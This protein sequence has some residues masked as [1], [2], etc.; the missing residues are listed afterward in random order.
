MGKPIDLKFLQAVLGTLPI[1]QLTKSNETHPLLLGQIEFDAE[2]IKQRLA[3]DEKALDEILK[4]YNGRLY[5]K[6]SF[7]KKLE[8]SL[9]ARTQERL[10]DT[11]LQAK[12]S[13]QIVPSLLQKRKD[14][15]A[16]RSEYQIVK[17]KTDFERELVEHKHRVTET[18]IPPE[19]FAEKMVAQLPQ[20]N[21][22]RHQYILGA[23]GSG[24][25][26]LIKL[27]AYH[28]IQQ[29]NHGVF[30]LDPHGELCEDII[31]FRGKGEDFVYLS[32]EF[33]NDGICFKYNIFDHD[34]HDQPDIVKQPFISMR[35]E[36]LLGSFEK[37]F[38]A[39]FTHYMK[40]L[41]FNSMMLL[42]NEK[43][44]KLQDLLNLLRPSTE[45]KYLKMAKH[46]YNENVRMYFEYD[47]Q[48]K[49]L[50]ITRMSV[51]TRFE[52]ALSNYHLNNIMDAEK[53]SFDLRQLLDS[54]KAVLMSLSQGI[55]G[56]EG[57]RILGIFLMSELTTHALRRQN[58]PKEERTP[59]FCYIDEMHNYCSERL[60]KILSEGR[61]Y[62]IHLILANQY[63][64]QFGEK[65]RQLKESILAN[66]NIKMFGATSSKDYTRMAKE[67]DFYSGS[68]PMLRHG[69]FVLKVGDCT[70]VL[71][72]A[73][74]HLV[75]KTAEYYLPPT[76]VQ[77]RLDWQKRRYYVSFDPGQSAG[78]TTTTEFQ[79]IIEKLI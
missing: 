11:I 49:P 31:R 5:G 78:N 42:L 15:T 57:S 60:D 21:R 14:F 37:I 36:E 10:K 16:P 47:F 2:D 58:Q 22:E 40:R 39:D 73:S 69:K 64:D 61:K 51:I 77:K 71:V 18:M 74:G 30:V 6:L 34:Y 17:S 70:P 7:L 53:S 45:G 55:I 3:K 4:Y 38:E 43:G 41:I 46:H 68:V 25:S 32:A 23:S 54:S 79:P 76:Q 8:D 1:P 33:A 67:T 44:S 66:C 72:Q 9:P 27:E 75:K 13:I 65:N 20:S 26:E 24:K 48:A 12:R 35:A 52:N 19:I 63:L 56:E 50:L 59:I 28:D 29:P 62:G